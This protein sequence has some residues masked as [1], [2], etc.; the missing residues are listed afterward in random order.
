MLV[1]W[2]GSDQAG[3]GHQR[4]NESQRLDP[5]PVRHRRGARHRRQ[6]LKGYNANGTTTR[7]IS[8]ATTSSKFLREVSGTAANNNG[9]KSARNTFYY[10]DDDGLL[11]AM[12][13]GD[14]KASFAEQRMPG[15]MAV[16]G[17]PFVKLR[18]TKLYNLMQDP[19]ERADITSNTYW[20][21]ILNHV[22]QVYQGMEGVTNFIVSFKDTRR[23]P[24]PRASTRPTC[25][26]TPCV[27]LRP[28]RSSNTRSRCCERN[29]RARR[30][31]KL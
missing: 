4:V 16:W 27:I 21:W 19:Y 26:K 29:Q 5:D 30:N 11:V 17:E 12:R 7:F 1:R 25:W 18:M 8:T 6:V 28:S 14:Y 2:P 22:P 31:R 15:M 20:D 24:S 10:T 3:H 13:I 9:V 23:A